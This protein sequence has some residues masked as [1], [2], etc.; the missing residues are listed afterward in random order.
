[1]MIKY[2]I[3]FRWI[4]PVSNHNQTF[5][6][7]DISVSRDADP[8]L[9]PPIQFHLDVHIV[10][11]HVDKFPD[12]ANH[13]ISHRKIRHFLQYRKSGNATMRG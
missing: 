7:I 4:M 3:F 12:K 11:Q 1:M 6:N 5:S 10:S 13:N 9:F 2:S 8:E